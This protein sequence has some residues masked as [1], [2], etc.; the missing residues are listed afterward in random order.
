MDLTAE[1]PGLVLFAVLL[2]ANAFFVAAEY[3]LVRV[4]ETQLDELAGSGSARAK[5]A[6][7]MV[8]ELESYISAAQLGVTLCSLLLG[9]SG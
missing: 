5:L 9:F 1:L 8:R 4:R 3:S 6:A 7:R 2:F